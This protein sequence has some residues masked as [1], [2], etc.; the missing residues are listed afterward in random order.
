MVNQVSLESLL[1]LGCN[2]GCGPGTVLL[3]SVQKGSSPFFDLHANIQAESQS[4]ERSKEDSAAGL[5]YCQST[6]TQ[7]EWASWEDRYFFLYD[8]VF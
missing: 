1:T 8:T 3:K 4:A 2:W 7:V 5:N 6:T